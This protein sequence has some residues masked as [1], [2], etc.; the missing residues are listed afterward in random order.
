MWDKALNGFYEF[1]RGGTRSFN[2][3]ELSILSAVQARLPIAEQVVFQKQI[4]SVSLVQR[5]QPGRM[6]I[7]FYGKHKKPPE[8]PYMGYEYCLAVASYVQEGRKK[9]VQV[10]LHGGR[11]QSLEGSVP[12]ANH[13]AFLVQE[14]QLH[15]NGVRSVT[16]DI[17]AEEHGNPT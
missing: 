9:K 4:E 13:Q 12:V 5:P 1:F 8:L 6:S 2:N 15:P 14:V 3:G 16:E 7:G 17:D 11:L 10:M